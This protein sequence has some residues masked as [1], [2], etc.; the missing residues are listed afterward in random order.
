MPLEALAI[1]RLDALTH[2]KEPINQAE[3]EQR[4][5]ALYLDYQNP[6][7][8][9]HNTETSEQI[10][11]ILQASWQQNPHNCAY[12]GMFNG[13]PIACVGCF[14]DGVNE[15]RRLQYLSVHLANRGRG[16][17]Q[18]FIKQVVMV[19]RKKGIRQFMPAETTI[20]QILQQYELG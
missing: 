9:T 5:T 17:E 4:L 18:K 6:D 12:L 15:Q 8:F 13:K 2:A 14:D 3:L 1:S 16:I 20:H 7:N 19:E 11:K 10:V